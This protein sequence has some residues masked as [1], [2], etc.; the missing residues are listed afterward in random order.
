MSQRPPGQNQDQEIDSVR[1][2]TNWARCSKPVKPPQKVEA[3]HHSKQSWNQKK[4]FVNQLPS[5]KT[6]YYQHK[7]IIEIPP[8][9]IRFTEYS[10]VG[11]FQKILTA[12]FGHAKNYGNPPRTGTP[13]SVQDPK[14]IKWKGP[15]G[16]SQKGQKNKMWIRVHCLKR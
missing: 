15:A 6:D 10:T 3:Q 14:E 2:K 4:W 12:P 8:K 7:G 9:W 1:S 11:G 5:R 16:N 13:L